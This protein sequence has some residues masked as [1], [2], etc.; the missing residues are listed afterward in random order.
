M[1]DDFFRTWLRVAAEEAKHFSRWRLRLAQYGLR[2]GDLDAHEGLWQSALETGDSLLA[3]LAVVHC[4]HEARGLD[5]A[6]LM[7]A[8]LGDDAASVAVLDANVEEEVTHVAAGREWIER[9]CAALP[10]AE[11]PEH[12]RL[13]FQACV[14]ARFFGRLLPPFAAERRA[15]AGLTE[16]WYLPLAAMPAEGGKAAELT[17][18]DMG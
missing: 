12:P 15:R 8:K 16:E 14:R 4:V 5:V 18:A 3:R 2:Y 11:R 1:P 17:A 6:P 13:A 7:R 10:A 9:V